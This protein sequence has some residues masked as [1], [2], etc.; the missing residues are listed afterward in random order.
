MDTNNE[1]MN[2]DEVVQYLRITRK[3]L[4]KLIKDGQLKA[5]KVGK[6]YRYLKTEIDHFL[7]GSD[8]SQEE[9]NYFQ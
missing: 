9:V 2:T 7:R 1:V 6:N 5:R 4:L 8:S 3:T